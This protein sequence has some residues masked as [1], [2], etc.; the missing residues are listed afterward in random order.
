MDLSKSSPEHSVLRLLE[1]HKDLF[2]K[3]A[4]RALPLVLEISGVGII[5]VLE[6]RW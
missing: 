3:N 4:V 2:V 5:L 6:R 1:G